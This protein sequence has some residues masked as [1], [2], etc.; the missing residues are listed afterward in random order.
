ML[1]FLSKCQSANCLL[2]MRNRMTKPYYVPTY[3]KNDGKYEKE[4]W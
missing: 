3:S 2:K 1:L 4:K